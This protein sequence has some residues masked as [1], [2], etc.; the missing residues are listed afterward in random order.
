MKPVFLLTSLALIIGVSSVSAQKKS[1]KK[2]SAIVFN[3]N[4]SD[5]SFLKNVKDSSLSKTISQKGWLK[6]A[7]KSLGVAIGVWKK[8]TPHI[9]LSGTLTGT[10]SSFPANFVK[11]DSIGQ[12][13]FSPQL[14]ALLHFKLLKEK[15][16]VNPFLT[17]GIGAGYFPKQFAAYVP[18]GTGLY[19]HFK[20]GTAMMLQAQWRKALTDGINNDYMHY[21]LGFTFNGKMNKPVKKQDAK[22]ALP[23]IDSLLVN[24]D[25][26]GD[27]IA[28]SKD[29]C[30]KLKGTLNGCPDSDND[31]IADKDDK[32]KDIAGTAKNGGCP[33]ADADNDGISDDKDKCPGIAGTQE[34]NGCPKVKEEIKA[35]VKRASKNIFFEFASDVIVMKTSETSLNEVVAILNANPEMELK[36]EAHADNRGSFGSN[37][38]WSEKRA[39][40]VAD[41]FIKNGIAASRII[42]KGY[43]DTRPIA[44]NDTPEGRAKNRRVEMIVHY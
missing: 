31:G 30:P 22:K 7:D 26:D 34:D 40:A 17:A 16:T 44:T 14:D 20:E 10:F 8:L 41:Y 4:L 36:I 15:A 6:P 1:V 32:C 39:K 38:L 33:F 37:I 35:T 11:G 23:A 28:D 13:S 42:F 24:A 21:S 18:I 9:D 27:G 19:F 5:Y 12:A 43:G 2:S 25:S 29:D 3:I